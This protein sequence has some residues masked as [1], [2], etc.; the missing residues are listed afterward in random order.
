MVITAVMVSTPVRYQQGHQMIYHVHRNIER[1]YLSLHFA[2][3]ITGRHRSVVTFWFSVTSASTC[4]VAGALFSSLLLSHCQSSQPRR[5]REDW[6]HPA[7][8]TRTHYKVW[9][10]AGVGGIRIYIS[11]GL[12]QQSR[13]LESAGAFHS[14]GP[15]SRGHS[16]PKG[17]KT[18]WG[19]AGRARCSAN[20]CVSPR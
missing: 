8:V 2:V 17:W 10:W 15:M 20:L 6:C 4:C 3:E 14:P 1:T 7:L 5:K 12:Q 16:F 9:M 11:C 19:R 18:H 13:E